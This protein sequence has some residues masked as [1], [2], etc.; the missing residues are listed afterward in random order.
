MVVHFFGDILHIGVNP[1][2][3]VLYLFPGVPIF[4]FTSGFL[5][6]ASWERRPDIRIFAINRFLRIYPA[7]VAAFLFSLFGIVLFYRSDLLKHWASFGAW[8]I[9]QLTLGQGWTPV[10]LHSYG[11]GH[12]NASL[13]TIPVEISFYICVPLLYRLFAITRRADLVLLVIIVMSTTLA[14]VLEP[15]SGKG[16][17]RLLT[18]SP[19]TTIGMFCLGI[20]VQRHRDRAI[21]FAR[22]WA[23]LLIPGYVFVMILGHFADAAPAAQLGFPFPGA[24]QSCDARGRG[25]GGGI[26]R[27][28]SGGETFAPAGYFLPGFICFTCLSRTCCWRTASPECPACSR[29]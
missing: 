14:N 20:L 15:Y 22:R 23:L 7:L 11:M 19:L 3:L 4:F 8:A 21:P 17:V 16:I 26:L 27:A 24:R 10:F 18:L 28:Q 12:P 13:W 5:V 2:L 6:S 9:A 1:L 25:D 29:R